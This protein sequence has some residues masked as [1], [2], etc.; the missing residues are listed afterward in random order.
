MPEFGPLSDNCQLME[1]YTPP[2]ATQALSRIA[3][4]AMSF[5]DETTGQA[6]IHAALDQGINCFDTADLYDKGE[7]ERILGKVLAHRR[8]EVFLATKVGNRWRVDG[9]GWDWVPRRA[10]MLQAIEDSLRRLGTDYIDLYQLHG[11]TI[12]DPWDEIIGTFEELKVA[13]KILAYGVSSIRPNVIRNWTANSQGSTCM[14]Q[15]SLLDRRPEE[16]TLQ[17]LQD[18]GQYA[19]VRGALAKGLLAGKPSRDYLGYSA[20]TVTAQY[21]ALVAEVGVHA[22]GL[23]IAYVF[24]QPAV[25]SVVLGASSAE[26]INGAVQAWQKIRANQVNW[27]ALMAIAPAKV[28]ELHR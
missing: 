26:Q 25:G 28:Y 21:Q 17:S 13:G 3:L 18:A 6:V 10:Y 5:H 11:G 9:S 1:Y 4:G 20:D 14:T 8:K 15:Y 12:D 16:A 24:R 7:N 27:P 19:L 23:A 22:A 2:F